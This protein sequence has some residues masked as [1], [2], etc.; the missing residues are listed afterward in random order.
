MGLPKRHRAASPVDYHLPNVI[1]GHEWVGRQSVQAVERLFIS[2]RGMIDISLGEQ[3]P[4]EA[5]EARESPLTWAQ[6][7]RERRARL[8]LGQVHY[9]AAARIDIIFSL[10]G[11]LSTR[12]HAVSSARL[13]GRPLVLCRRQRRNPLALIGITLSGAQCNHFAAAASTFLLAV[14]TAALVTSD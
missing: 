10:A 11:T 6:N 14:M 5:G 7:G 3:G 2:G 13:P 12:S 1:G 8:Y 9:Q 4:L